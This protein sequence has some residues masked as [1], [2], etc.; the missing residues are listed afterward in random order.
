MLLGRPEAL[1]LAW[2]LAAIKGTTDRSALRALGTGLGAAAAKLGEKEAKEAV[3]PLLAAIKGTNNPY[4]LEALGTGLGA[5]P[6]KLG[7][8]EA[9]EAVEPLLAA[10]KGT[11]DPSALR[12][13]RVWEPSRPS[14]IGSRQGL[15][16]AWL[17]R[18]WKEHEIRKRSRSMPSCLQS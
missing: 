5:V 15:R 18:C 6:A 4:A 2:W 8:K 16:T 10:I 13:A 17:T 9:K 12:A 11:T 7:E 3:E 1:S 14:L